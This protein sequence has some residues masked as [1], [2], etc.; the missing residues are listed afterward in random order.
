MSFLSFF[1]FF[2][3]LCCLHLVNAEEVKP[4]EPHFKNGDHNPR[5]HELDPIQLLKPKRRWKDSTDHTHPGTKTHSQPQPRQRHHKVDNKKPKPP[6]QIKYAQELLKE[7]QHTQK[8]A[9]QQTEFI[10]KQPSDGG[11][12]VKL[13]I[14]A[15]IYGWTLKQAI[16]DY[17]LTKDTKM[18]VIDLTPR[19]RRFH[20]V[21]FLIGTLVANKTLDLG[22]IAC[23]TGGGVAMVANKFPG[24]YAAVG[25]DAFDVVRGRSLYGFNV[26]ALGGLTT[27]PEKA[28]ALINAFLET[29]FQK[30]WIPEILELVGHAHEEI[31]RVESRIFRPVVAPSQPIAYN[32]NLLPE[33]KNVSI[34]GLEEAQ[35]QVLRSDA[36]GFRAVIRFPANSTIP[37]HFHYQG[38]DLYLQAGKISISNL[39]HKEGGQS[40]SQ[41]QPLVLSSPGGYY[42]I[43]VRNSVKIVVHEESTL[44]VMCEGPFEWRWT[45]SRHQSLVR[46][47]EKKKN[48]DKKVKN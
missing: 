28:L 18:E 15:D 34:Q 11:K 23:A 6:D 33:W 47:G 14:A 37:P 38:V 24:V 44:L 7:Q 25:N 41:P 27:T 46:D 30:G 13:G 19:P 45:F 21:G 1:S 48:L 22:I 29:N 42:Y 3:L 12:V 35:W 9:E 20:D 32:S 17:F 8:T 43:P 39:S 36:T 10:H 4:Q 2:T 5:A 26:L 31:V 40:Q 16:K